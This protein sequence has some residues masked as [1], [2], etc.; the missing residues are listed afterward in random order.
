MQI[1]N[2]KS[3]FIRKPRPKVSQLP[4]QGELLNFDPELAMKFEQKSASDWID[5]IKQRS[6][7]VGLVEPAGTVVG[8]VSQPML[9]L[10]T[11]GDGAGA[12]FTGDFQGAGA[13]VSTVVDRAYNPQGLGGKIYSSGTAIKALSGAAVGG[14]EVYAG[15]K[16]NN[17]YLTMMGGA[18]L[19]GAASHV[20]NIA[21]AGGLALGLS[22]ASTAS[23]VGL[24]LAKPKEFSRTQKVKTILD[25]SGSVASAMLKN[26]FLVGPALGVTAVAGIGQMAYM[27]HPGFRK[28]VDGILD[29]IFPPK[30]FGHNLAQLPPNKPL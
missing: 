9:N 4:Q 17:K 27:N 2:P 3:G 15:L 11:I 1:S 30:N 22:I 28:A 5:T 10:R 14:L 26:G 16:S 7:L 19:L 13:A 29:R 23:K 12:L 20:A 25:G 21:D 18:D 8:I 24:V 6:T